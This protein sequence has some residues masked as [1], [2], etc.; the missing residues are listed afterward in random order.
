MAG[1]TAGQD[2]VFTGTPAGVGMV[3]GSYLRPG[4][5]VTT[6]IDEVG[7]FTSRCV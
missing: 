6:A 2:V 1:V 7:S 3:T 4:D 5:V